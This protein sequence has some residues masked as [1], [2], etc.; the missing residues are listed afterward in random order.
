M[1]ALEAIERTDRGQRVDDR[2]PSVTSHG[3]TIDHSP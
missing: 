2:R 1:A 3:M